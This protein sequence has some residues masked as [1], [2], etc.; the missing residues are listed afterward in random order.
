M[1]L[2]PDDV[3]EMCSDMTYEV[4][5]TTQC[6]NGCRPGVYENVAFLNI[7]IFLNVKKCLTV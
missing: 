5:T 3:S 7:I 2:G 6:I 4:L 1:I